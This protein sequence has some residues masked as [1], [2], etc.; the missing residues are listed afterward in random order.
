MSTREYAQDSPEA[1]S[2]LSGQHLVKSQR[3][4]L[5]SAGVKP[6]VTGPSKLELGQAV[7]RQEEED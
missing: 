5:D 4:S 1:S 6:R 2:L 7:S 3:K